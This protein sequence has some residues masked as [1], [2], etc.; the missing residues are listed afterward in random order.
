[1]KK[2]YITV[3][4]MPNHFPFLTVGTLRHLIFEKRKGIHECIMRFGKKIY[5][6]KEKFENWVENQKSESKK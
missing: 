1:M 6:D 2:E 4:D 3:K 5:F